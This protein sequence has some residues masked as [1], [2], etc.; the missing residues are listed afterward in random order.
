MMPSDEHCIEYWC[1]ALS[2]RNR[3]NTNYV[4]LWPYAVKELFPPE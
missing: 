3:C 2:D 1:T 4:K